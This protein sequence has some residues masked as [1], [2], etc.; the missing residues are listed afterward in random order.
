MPPRN[1]SLDHIVSFVSSLFTITVGPDVFHSVILA[2]RVLQVVYLI[3]HT[4]R[5]SNN[6]TAVHVKRLIPI[7]YDNSAMVKR[8]T[9]RRSWVFKKSSCREQS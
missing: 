7:L 8:H 5:K 6:E 1:Q 2:F 9:D 3:D 4:R